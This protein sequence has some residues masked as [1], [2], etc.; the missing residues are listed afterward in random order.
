[1]RHHSSTTRV[2]AAA[3][4]ILLALIVVLGVI[5]PPLEYLPA[6]RWGSELESAGLKGIV[7]FLVLGIL[8]TSVGL[9]RQMLAFIG[10]L[11]Y[12]VTGGLSISL[13]AALGGCWLTA[14]VSRRFFASIVS[15]RFPGPIAALDRLTRKDLFLKVLV[16]RLQPLGTNLLTNVCIGFTSA[17]VPG[18][19]AASAV[20]YIPQMLVFNLLGVGV[21]VDSQ[22]QLLLSLFL[23]AIS[24]V[25]GVS[26]YKRHIKT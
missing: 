26:L 13:L 24:I 5:F 23:L 2:I 10:G 25:L 11:A 14:M 3:L 21:R 9:P 1:M 8:A 19:V 12:G 4:L 6:A 22:A 17:S 20:G 15:T 18:F 16:L 7:A